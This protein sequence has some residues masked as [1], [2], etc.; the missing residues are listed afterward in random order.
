M[1]VRIYGRFRELVDRPRL[2]LDVTHGE[3]IQALIDRLGLPGEA[4]DL[5]ACVNHVPA[6]RDH[7]LE[8]GEQ[9]MLFQPVAGGF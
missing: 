1:E 2:T 9:I 7:Q 3:T 5:W 8:P 4:P 6:Q